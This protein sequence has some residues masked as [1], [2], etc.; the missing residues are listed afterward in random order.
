MIGVPEHRRRCVL[1]LGILLLALEL[2]PPSVRPLAVGAAG[3][4]VVDSA[5]Q[6]A[7]RKPART[8]KSLEIDARPQWAILVD[9][10]GIENCR[11]PFRATHD[12]T[13]GV[14]KDVAIDP[15]LVQHP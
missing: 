12:V 4:Q 13:V 7:L 14:A 2:M 11:F 10:V 5:S 3:N 6:R 1:L 9:A 8:L 15:R